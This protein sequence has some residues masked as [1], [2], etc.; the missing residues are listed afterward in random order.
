VDAAALLD[1]S[2]RVLANWRSKKVGPRFVRLRGDSIRY[3]MGALK[4]FAE[5]RDRLE[6]DALPDPSIVEPQDVSESREALAVHR[7]VLLASSTA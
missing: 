5:G 7:E 3:Q 6:G 1:T 4:A 2:P